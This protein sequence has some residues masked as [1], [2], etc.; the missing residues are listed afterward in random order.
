METQLN[1]HAQ[2]ACK[3][4]VAT[5]ELLEKATTD[6]LSLLKRMD[7]IADQL[8]EKEIS[9][10]LKSLIIFTYEVCT[11]ED[12]ASQHLG[13]VLAM[14]DENCELNK[15]YTDNI[16]LS[17]PAIKGDSTMSQDEIDNILD[18]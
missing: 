4:L 9:A 18:F 11:F 13:K 7:I 3:H 6:I 17:G 2:E 15:R 14:L 12:L 16:M 5:S 10:Q 1:D 8:Q